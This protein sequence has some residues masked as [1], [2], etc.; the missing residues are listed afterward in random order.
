MI[1]IISTLSLFHSL[2]WAL[3]K[4]F[5]S[6]SLPN[7]DLTHLLFLA[8]I[9]GCTTAGHQV[10]NT[11]SEVF[12]AQAPVAAAPALT[13]A[14]TASQQLI[15]QQAAAQGKVEQRAVMAR[16]AHPLV[17]DKAE[18]ARPVAGAKAKTLY[19]AY[20]AE[21]TASFASKL[22]HREAQLISKEAV[23][24]VVDEANAML[25]ES[26]FLKV[27]N[28]VDKLKEVR[29]ELAA[30]PVITT[31]G[32]PGDLRVWIGDINHKANFPAGMSSVSATIPT[33]MNPK[34][35]LVVPNAPAFNIEPQ[36]KCQ[37]FDPTGTTVNFQLMPKFEREDT[38]PVGARIEI[39]DGDNCKGDPIPKAAT[40]IFVKVVVKKSPDDIWKLLR[41]NIYELLAGLFSLTIAL[42]LFMAR[43]FLKKVFGSEN[44]EN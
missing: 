35:V 32:P 8:F 2:K 40:D 22:P 31:P 9:T 17:E 36:N 41:E 11:S 39:F 15:V 44:K 42:L 33:S 26:H 30:T 1:A 21:G 23:D 4:V 14:P 43:K 5:K 16:M 18:A 29:A 12:A 25:A 10:N 6:S 20:H 19:E 3:C 28:G 37:Q 24:V 27:K 38:Y 13:S 34:T 7:G